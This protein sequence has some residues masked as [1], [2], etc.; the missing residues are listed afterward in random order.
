MVGVA[1]KVTLVPEHILLA[2]APIVT[3]TGRFGLTVMTTVLDVAGLPVAQVALDVS[4]TVTW[5][6]LTGV[7]VK[8]V[9]LGPVFTPFTCHWYEGVNPPLVGVAVNVTGV[10]EQTG[11]A[12][13]TIET[14][15]GNELFTV[16]V[17][18]FEVAGLP[19]GQVALEV[20]IHVT[21]SLFT[22]T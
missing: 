9:L 15:T 13:A 21:T 5:S 12:E 10:A 14:L 6:L 8:L 16:M 22:G 7:Y 4:I 11:L 18:E 2:D 20:S 17:M 1:V 19:V 3:L